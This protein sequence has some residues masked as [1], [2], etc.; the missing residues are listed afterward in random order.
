MATILQ[1]VDPDDLTTIWFD[2]ND[3]TGLNNAT[4]A[5]N[6]KTNFAVGGAFNLNAP[7]A[8]ATEYGPD[9]A[10]AAQALYRLEP[11]VQS[12]FRMAISQTDYA[13]LRKGVGFLHRQLSSGGVIKFVPHGASGA[14]V[15]FID[16]YPSP[17]PA[18]MKG[19]EHELL[20]LASFYEPR[21]VPIILNRKALMRGP[22]IMSAV[23]VLENATLMRDTNLDGTPDYWSESGGPAAGENINAA[24]ECLEFTGT[25]AAQSWFQA[26]SGASS[27]QVWTASADGWYVSGSSG[28]MRVRMEFLNGSSVVVGTFDSTVV[29][30]AGTGFVRLSASGTAPATTASV[31]ILLLTSSSATVVYR[32]RNAQLEQAASASPFR[33]GNE[34]M[35]GV[36]GT[37]LGRVLPLHITGDAPAPIRMSVK[38]TTSGTG[39]TQLRTGVRSNGGRTGLYELPNFLNELAYIDLGVTVRGWTHSFGT[40]TSSVATTSADIGSAVARCTNATEFDYNKLVRRVKMTRTTD[41]NA[42]RGSWHVYLAWRGG[43][44]GK[45]GKVQLRWSAVT[46]GEATYSE[47]PKLITY[48]GASARQ[49]EYLGRVHFPENPLVPLSGAALEIWESYNT[50][51]TNVDLDALYLVP[52]QANLHMGNLMAPGGSTDTVVPSTMTTPPFDVGAADPTWIAAADNGNKVTM[53]ADNEAVGLGSNSGTVYSGGRW[54][55]RIKVTGYDGLDD[56]FS[57]KLRVVKVTAT[58]AEVAVVTVTPGGNSNNPTGWHGYYEVTFDA[59]GTSAYQFQ[60]NLMEAGAGGGY[61]S[62]DELE[63]SY[64]PSVTQNQTIHTDPEWGEGYQLDSS[65]NLVARLECDGPVPLV[66]EPGLNLVTLIAREPKTSGGS[67]DQEILGR[68]YTVSYAYYPRYWT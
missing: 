55:F 19:E 33:V 60:V 39:M 38:P 54:K 35:N 58:A 10:G 66:A 17:L 45:K 63:Y 27:G 49:I 4:Y 44:D 43:A 20:L 37:D 25:V 21:G 46:T 64:I 16:F 14:E 11:V 9:E 40:D 52:A 56:T 32:W 3:P 68:A 1:I 34:T 62:L 7:D 48:S 26:Q 57:W 65:G 36:P 28:N 47:D 15:R 50:Q 61:L 13:S 30:T 59:D 22:Q 2:F 42:L 29:T 23:N 12:D 53:D 8:E 31:R 6:L 67:D 51:T 5:G 24:H 41:M 18:M